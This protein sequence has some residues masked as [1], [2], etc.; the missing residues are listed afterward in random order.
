MKKLFFLLLAFSVCFGQQ[1]KKTET[2]YDTVIVNQIVIDTVH[3]YIA[4]SVTLKALENSEKF[5]DSSFT[6]MQSSFSTFTNKVLVI[7]TILGFFIAALGLINSLSSNSLKKEVRKELASV[8]D[9][10]KKLSEELSKT[11]I[12][13]D[14]NIGYIYSEFACFY[15]RLS[16]MYF[17][18]KGKSNDLN[19]YSGIYHFNNLSSY[20]I[21]LTTHKI[22]L[23]E[24]SWKDIQCMKDFVKEYRESDLIDAGSFISSLKFFIDYCKKI[25]ESRGLAEASEL[26]K[27]LCGKFGEDAILETLANSNKRR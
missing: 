2:I 14:K 13:L 1:P 4:D 17:Y 19:N 5:Y 25:G 11:K 18:E 10:G 22:N 21:I 20:F 24:D 8:K 23:N 15:F 7:I 16:V 6:K 27:A 26:W 9:F 12:E 3:R